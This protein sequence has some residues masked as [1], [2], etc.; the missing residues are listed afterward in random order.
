MFRLVIQG[1]LL[2]LISPPEILSQPTEVVYGYKD[3]EVTSDP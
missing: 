2:L 3:L 1:Y